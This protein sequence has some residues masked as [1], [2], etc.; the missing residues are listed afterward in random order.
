[1]MAV[2]IVSVLLIMLFAVCPDFA[3]ASQG[4]ANDHFTDKVEFVNVPNGGISHYI[5]VLTGEPGWFS[6]ND[7]ELAFT[8]GYL[9]ANFYYRGNDNLEGGGYVYPSVQAK[10]WLWNPQIMDW[11]QED[12]YDIYCKK[13][14][15]I[16]LQEEYQ[17]YCIELYFWRATTTADSYERYNKSGFSEPFTHDGVSSA[18]WVEG[19]LP[20]VVAVSDGKAK[21]FAGDPLSGFKKP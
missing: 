4:S 14:Y 12:T 2:R 11:T 20:S 6:S 16:E 18:V 5:Y 8:K 19:M 9:S 7:I 21:I 1:M 15:T 3:Y 13:D 17:I 10:I